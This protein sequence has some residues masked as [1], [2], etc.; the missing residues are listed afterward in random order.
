MS[1]IYEIITDKIL[2]EIEAG[3]IPWQK[4]WIGFNK[5][6]FNRITRKSYSFLNQML[7]G[8]PGEWA[9][10]KQWNSLGGK[11]KK[12]EKGSMIVFWKFYNKNETDGETDDDKNKKSYPVLR[13]YYVFHI[14][15][16]EGVEP[17]EENTT[18]LL[19]KMKI[20]KAEN[21][22]FN[23]LQNENIK[24]DQ[25]LCDSACYNPTKDLIQLPLHSQFVNSEEYY[26]TAFHEVIHSTGLQTRC[27]RNTLASI[28]EYAYA[29]EEL[30]AE[31]GSAY[32]MHTLDLQNEDLLQNSASYLDYWVKSM[33]QDSKYI[34]R[35]SS[36]AEKAAGYVFKSAECEPY[37]N[38]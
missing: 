23:Y 22:L 31:L 9:T 21:L 30:V 33:C 11:I 18:T 12:D 29:K 13:H 36:Q 1:N 17:L 15:Q 2:G 10:V 3:T 25:R 4:P 6:A 16:V 19:P 7:L 34:V 35:V 32:I 5:G 14:S 27:N 26:G 28:E 24:L 20:D 37:E 38:R 8:M